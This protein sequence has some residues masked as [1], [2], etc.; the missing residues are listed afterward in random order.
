MR[1]AIACDHAGYPLKDEV[2]AVVQESGL[3]V[4]D[5]GTYDQEPVDYPDYAEK[6]GRAITQGL[7]DR[8]IVICGSGV[9]ACIAAN[10]IKGV[11]ACLCHDTYSAHQGVEHDHMN[12]LCLGGRVIG[13]EL[14]KEIVRSFIAATF[15]NKER[16]MRRVGKI[17][18]LESNG[19]INTPN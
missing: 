17:L 4:I 10:K 2:I 3:D 16:H 8:A 1:I 9:G 18:Q 7:A 6:A 15:S 12:V 19:K 13:P 14:A 11:Y 5:L